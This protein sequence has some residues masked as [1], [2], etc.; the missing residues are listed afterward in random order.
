MTIQLAQ[1]TSSAWRRVN[2]SFFGDHDD[3]GDG[4]DARDVDEV[5]DIGDVGD[6]CD[7]GDVND[8]GDVGNYTVG[9]EH[10]LSLK[11]GEKVFAV[12]H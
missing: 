2:R 5:C 10:E 12:L 1:N 9:T 11:E 8:V 4:G 7:V 6:V 3:F